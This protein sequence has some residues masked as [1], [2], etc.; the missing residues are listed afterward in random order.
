[1]VDMALGVGGRRS[2]LSRTAPAAARVG[3]EERVGWDRS[4]FAELSSSGGAVS[5]VAS[6]PLALD[7]HVA[8][9]PAVTPARKATDIALQH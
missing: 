3:G 2:V 1:M 4:E 9:T 8:S 7:V 6:L 5:A